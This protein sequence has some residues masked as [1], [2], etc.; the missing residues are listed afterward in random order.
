MLLDS[1][2]HQPPETYRALVSRTVA[3][4]GKGDQ[5]PART[6]PQLTQPPSGTPAD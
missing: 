3:L 1:S 2:M 4:E 6:P 5:G